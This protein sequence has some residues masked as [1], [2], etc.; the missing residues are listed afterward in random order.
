MIIRDGLFPHDMISVLQ[1]ELMHVVGQNGHPAEANSIAD[2][3]INTWPTQ[4]CQSDLDFMANN[5]PSQPIRL[6]VL[7]PTLYEKTLPAADFWNTALNTQAFTVH[8]G[9]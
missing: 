9:Y 4:P 2:A 3:T 5:L 6:I 1:H 8:A 7:D